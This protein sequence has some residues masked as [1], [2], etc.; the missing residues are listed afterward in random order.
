MEGELKKLTLKDI[1]PNSFDYN[2]KSLCEK[3]ISCIYHLYVKLI[4]DTKY[5]ITVKRIFTEINGNCVIVIIKK[6]KL[7]RKIITQKLGLS[8]NRIHNKSLRL[9]NMCLCAVHVNFVFIDTNHRHSVLRKYFD[10]FIHIFNN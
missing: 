2:A 1:Y 10:L 9:H 4:L 7:I 5:C 3:H 8:N 6:I